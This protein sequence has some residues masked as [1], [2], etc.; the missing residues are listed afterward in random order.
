MRTSS[1]TTFLSLLLSLILFSACHSNFSAMGNT[2]NNKSKSN[3]KKLIIGEWVVE[4]IN[5]GQQVVPANS[6]GR[7]IHFSFQSDGTTTFTGPSGVTERGRYRVENS[8]IYDPENP[9]ESPVEIV[10]INSSQ[11]V[12]AMVEDGEEMKMT[13]VPRE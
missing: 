11:L 6:L 8:K 13:L 1:T 9:G 4:S 12:I 3:S 7:E 10:S 2:A 5:V